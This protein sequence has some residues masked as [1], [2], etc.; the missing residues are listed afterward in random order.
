[1]AAAAKELGYFREVDLFVLGAERSFDKSAWVFGEK[2][3]K[4]CLWDVVQVI[5]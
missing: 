3:G 2:E 1:M 4:L 5:N